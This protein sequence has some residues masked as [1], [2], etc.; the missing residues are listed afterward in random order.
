M[1]TLNKFN[2]IGISVRTTNQNNKSAEDIGKLWEQ[3][4]R[5]NLSAKIPNKT[6]NNIYAIYTDYKGD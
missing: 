5:E 1:M 6:S 2:I 3:F 4:Y